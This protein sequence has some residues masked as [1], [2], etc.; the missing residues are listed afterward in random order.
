M[1]FDKVLLAD[2]LQKAKGDR[3]I[4]MFGYE[5]G[6]DS[7]YISRLLRCRLTKP[8]SAMIL[9]KIAEKASNDVT[10]EQLLGAAGYIKSCPE[11]EI[12]EERAI[13]KSEADILPSFLKR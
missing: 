5:A 4:N 13:G 3:S 7:G 8:P 10:I 6:V 2:L 11:P 1:V 9:S 12:M